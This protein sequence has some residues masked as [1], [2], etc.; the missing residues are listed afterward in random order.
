MNY[1]TI[2]APIV[3][4]VFM[5]IELIIKHPI[6]ESVKVEWTDILTAVVGTGVTVWGIVKNHKV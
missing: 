4:A 3:A 5:G 1:K 6:S 2:I